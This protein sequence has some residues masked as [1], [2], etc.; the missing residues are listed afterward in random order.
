METTIQAHDESKDFLSLARKY[1]EQ[2]EIWRKKA[3]SIIPE[4]AEDYYDKGIH[5]FINSI[6]LIFHLKV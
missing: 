6:A 5:F 2:A 4:N 3:N 1:N